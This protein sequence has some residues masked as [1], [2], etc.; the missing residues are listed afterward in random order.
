M[1]D[2]IDRKRAIIESIGDVQG[3][4]FGE[5]LPAVRDRGGS[6]DKALGHRVLR[7]YL[8]SVVKESDGPAVFRTLPVAP[9]GRVREPTKL[10]RLDFQAVVGTPYSSS[11]VAAT[12]R[13]ILFVPILKPD[14]KLPADWSFERPFLWTPSADE[15]SQLEKDYETIRGIILRGEGDSLSSSRGIGHGRIMMP[16]TSGRTREDVEA[17]DIGGR[18]VAVRRR[19]FFLRQPYTEWLLNSSHFEGSPGSRASRRPAKAR[20]SVDDV[21]EELVRIFD[22]HA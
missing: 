8:G 9:N 4:A 15:W 12:L 20:D 21:V 5:L 14:T 10:R 17:Y 11:A 16:K 1:N 19:A 7:E 2:E 18:R 13:A 6:T 3:K 22:R